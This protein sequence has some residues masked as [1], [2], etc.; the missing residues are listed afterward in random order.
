MTTATVRRNAVERPPAL[1]IALLVLAVSAV[2]TSG[3]LIAAAAAPALAIAFWR[4]AMASGVLVPIA[5]VRKRSE[6]RHMSARD[7]RLAIVAGGFLAAHFA[8]WVPS[9]RYTSVASATA[10]VAT[11][12]IWNALIAR[13]MGHHVPRRAWL[14][15]GISVAGAVALT[16]ADFS[17]SSRA[18][19]GDVLAIAG[20]ILA[21]LY[22]AVGGEVRRN[23][24]TTSYTTI[25]YSTAAL[26][27]LLV[28]VVGRLHLTGYSSKT[29]LQLVALTIGPQLLGHSVINRVLRTTPATVV[30]L[31]ILFEVPGAALIAW[32]ALH[33]HP[34]AA[35]LPGVALLLI[36]LAVVISGATPDV[37]P[38]VP[39]E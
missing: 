33:Q 8:T 14:G 3:P 23:V 37:E 35:I 38:S 2:S 13:G 26:L 20:A 1:D 39:V 19:T 5:L 7:R 6:L 11:Q 28:C 18:L 30:S 27:L 10:L 34:P 9:L 25:C 29:W 15:I 24:S 21:A 31:A 36:G 22:V 16:G 17:V 12:P 4:N 32:V